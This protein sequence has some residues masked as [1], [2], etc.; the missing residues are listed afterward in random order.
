[1]ISIGRFESL[2]FCSFSRLCFSSSCYTLSKLS[3][4]ILYRGFL[5]FFLTSLTFYFTISNCF[6]CSS[7][8][9][10]IYSSRSLTFSRRYTYSSNLHSFSNF[11]L[12]ASLALSISSSYMALS[13]DIAYLIRLILFSCRR[14][15]RTARLCATCCG[16]CDWAKEAKSSLTLSSS[17]FAEGVRRD[18]RIGVRLDDAA[19][20]L[21]LL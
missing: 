17:S 20:S 15:L 4:S 10:L 12:S 3:S 11:H 5:R 6:F 19:E 14:R 1:M 13:A 2:I 9:Y 8:F 18:R 16:D 21:R 7:F